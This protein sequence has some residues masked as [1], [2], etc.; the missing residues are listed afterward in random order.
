[1]NQEAGHQGASKVLSV[2]IALIDKD[3]RDRRQETGAKLTRTPSSIS[4]QF[5]V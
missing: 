4:S 2:T 3:E 5:S 1:M